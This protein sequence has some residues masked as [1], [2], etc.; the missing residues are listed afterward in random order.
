MPKK[1][2]AGGRLQNY[3]SKTGRFAKTD[4]IKFFEEKPLYTRKEKAI[5]KEENRR[6]QLFNRA[7]NSKDELV[8]EV[9]C[10]IE[11]KLPGCVQFIN[12]QRFDPFINKP[13][14][15]DIITRKSIIEVKSGKSGSKLYKQFLSQ[16]KYA[17]SRKKQHIVFAPNLSNMA[18]CCFENGGI[19]IVKDYE[20]LIREIK[21]FE[22]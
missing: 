10:E 7:K 13:R 9:F 6:E 15:F 20:S 12:A 11:K 21:E 1:K 8:F 5:K 19:K 2:G 22:K 14:E 4:Y 3:D 18:R 16:K 17:E